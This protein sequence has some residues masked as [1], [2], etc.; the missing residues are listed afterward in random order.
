MI[1]LS[2]RE[3]KLVGSLP[4]GASLPVW[5]MGGEVRQ[6]VWKG[7]ILLGEM[8]V[9]TVDLSVFTEGESME[10]EGKRAASRDRKCSPEGGREG[11]CWTLQG[12][13]SRGDKL[14]KVGAQVHQEQVDGVC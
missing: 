6:E 1:K 11:T 4:E 5:C 8:I 10:G 12:H 3:R 13:E 9:G 7:V 14:T 2:F